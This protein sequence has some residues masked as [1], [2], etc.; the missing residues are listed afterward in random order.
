MKHRNYRAVNQLHQFF[1]VKQN[2]TRFPFP[3]PT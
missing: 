1:I 2:E 3:V